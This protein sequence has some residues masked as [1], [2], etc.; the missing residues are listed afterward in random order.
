VR[1]WKG[2]TE[3]EEE[4]EEEDC[5]GAIVVELV[6]LRLRVCAVVV[7]AVETWVDGEA[8][9]DRRVLLFAFQR[10]QTEDKMSRVQSSSEES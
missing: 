4:E 1:D 9:L 6:V 8:G 2:E 3:E 5:D 10:R 7:M